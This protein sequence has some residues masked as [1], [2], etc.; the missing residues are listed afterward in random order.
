[1]PLLNANEIT[2]EA[3]MADVA[4]QRSHRN[5]LEMQLL[6]LDEGLAL[7]NNPLEQ[8]SAVR[9]FTVGAGDTLQIV[10]DRLWGTPEYWRALAQANGLEY[11]YLLVTGQVL[12][13]PTVA[14]E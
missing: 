10:S 3:L 8:S 7:Q 4:M 1:M 12:T 5:Q 9:T 6:T 14:T 2:V 13:V 11:P